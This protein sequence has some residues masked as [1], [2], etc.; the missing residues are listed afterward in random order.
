MTPLGLLLAFTAVTL[1]TL[2]FALPALL[3]LG[4]AWAAQAWPAIAA[5]SN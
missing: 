3:A 1:A 5:G 2:G 4:G